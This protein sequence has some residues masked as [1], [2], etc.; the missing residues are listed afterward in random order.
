MISALISSLEYRRLRMVC[1]PTQKKR[2][3]S[4]SPCRMPDL[5]VEAS[6][7]SSFEC[8]VEPY[9]GSV[10]EHEDSDE[11]QVSPLDELLENQSARDG[12]ICV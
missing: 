4:A 7:Y 1:T 3:A 9:R 5:H 11:V 12:A 8:H 2:G 10:A 6:V